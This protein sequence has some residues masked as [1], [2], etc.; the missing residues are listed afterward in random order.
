M[1]SFWLSF[2]SYCRFLVNFPES[3]KVKFS[4]LPLLFQMLEI[5]S[6]FLW[7]I[8]SMFWKTKSSFYHIFFLLYRFTSMCLKFKKIIIFFSLSSRIINL[9]NYYIKKFI[10]DFHTYT[11]GFFIYFSF[12]FLLFQTRSSFSFY[13]IIYLIIFIFSCLP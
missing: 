13:N 3:I 11:K 8:K 5:C 2:Y 12:F 6:E 9:K 7:A 4:L 10:V 1:L